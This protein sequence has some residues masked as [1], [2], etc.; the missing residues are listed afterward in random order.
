M[1]T[2]NKPVKSLPEYGLVQGEV[3]RFI[4]ALCRDCAC[5]FVLIA[6]VEKELD[7][8]LGGTKITTSLPGKALMAKFATSF[9][10]VIY[11]QR[12]ASK[13]TWSTAAEGVDLKTRN[14]PYADNLLPDFSQIVSKWKARQAATEALPSNPP[15]PTK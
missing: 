9:S 3:E 7:A 5:H 10:D 15:L 1:V 13:W 6:H 2:G 14:L 8:L 12:S 4:G 11:A